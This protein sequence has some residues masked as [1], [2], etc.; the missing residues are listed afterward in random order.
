MGLARGQLEGALTSDLEG[1]TTIMMY[2]HIQHAPSLQ[3]KKQGYLLDA[4]SVDGKGV[5]VLQVCNQGWKLGMLN[6]LDVGCV[7]ITQRV[8]QLA[9]GYY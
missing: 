5:I 6:G 4:T 8:H 9:I 3:S 1:G 2:G 7:W